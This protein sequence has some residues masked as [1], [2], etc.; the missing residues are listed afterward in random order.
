[1]HMTSLTKTIKYVFGMVMKGTQRITLDQN[2]CCF[3]KVSWTADFLYN[4]GLI[5]SQIRAGC[6]L[7]VHTC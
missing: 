6:L 7:H 2:H 5:I 1:M 4:L 3:F